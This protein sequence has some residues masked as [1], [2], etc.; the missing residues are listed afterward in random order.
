MDTKPVYSTIF[1]RRE[2][3]RRVAH[4]HLSNTKD[5]IVAYTAVLTASCRVRGTETLKWIICDC[6]K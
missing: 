1:N 4:H 2:A 3:H 6:N 5:F